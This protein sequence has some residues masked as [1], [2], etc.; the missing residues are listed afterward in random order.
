M[1]DPVIPS[2]GT[3]QVLTATT[4]NTAFTN[5]TTIVHNEATRA[6]AAENTNA[7]NISTTSSLLATE[8]ARAISAEG[9]LLSDVNAEATRAESVEQALNITL[10]QVTG[11]NGSNYVGDNQGAIGGSTLWTTVKGFIQYLLSSAGS[12]VVGFLQAGTGVVAR[13]VQAKL[14]ECVSLEDFG[15]VGD[16][17]TNDGPAAVL[18][19]NYCCATGATLRLKPRVYK[20]ARIEVH[21]TYCVEGNGATVMYLGVGQTIVLGTGTGSAA[22]PTAWGSDPGYQPSYPATTKYDLSVAPILGAISLT[23]SSVSGIT[24]GMYLF[25]CGNPTSLSSSNNFIP[26][27]FEF[28]RVVNIVGNVITLSA[29]LQSS[30]L[31]T[32]SGVFYAPGL[33]INCH[34][35]GLNISTTTDAYQQVVRSS[36]GCTIKDITFSGTSAVGASTFSD[37]LVYDNINVES[38]AGGGFSTGRGTV[39]TVFS[40]VNM[41]NY[42]SS[43]AFFF[44]ESAYKVTLDNFFAA[45]ALALGSFDCS[46]SQRHRQFTVQNSEF[47]PSIYGG[48]VSPFAAGTVIGIDLK[49]SNTTFYGAVTTPNAGNYPSITGDALIWQSASMASD[50]TLFNDCKFI[51]VNAGN[52]WPS[53]IGGFLG[54]VRFNSGC[55]FVT[56]TTPAQNESIATSLTVPKVNTTI[57]NANTGGSFFGQ[58][59][60]VS[61]LQMTATNLYFGAAFGGVPSAEVGTINSYTTSTTIAPF[62]AQ[63]INGFTGHMYASECI[64]AAGTGWMHFIGQSGNGTNLTTNN[65]FIYGNGNI[66]NANNSYGA[67]SDIKLKEN[68]TVCTPKL[69]KLN[70]VRV[71]NYNL[72]T[73]PTHKQIGV[74]AQEVEAIFPGM[75]EDTPDFNTVE[76]TREILDENGIITIEKYSENVYTGEFTKSVKYSVFI[77]MLIKAMQEQTAFISALEARIVSL[78]SA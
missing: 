73:D 38:A 35:S 16:G 68:I 64:T 28:F 59:G 44:E 18:A 77:P 53:A 49:I 67:I 42:T 15:A 63:A 55:T 17:V 19:C 31:T 70:Q 54:T 48:L 11:T 45:G 51:S 50:L 3:G 74:I 66:V 13:S 14:R 5:E 2:F 1:T 22:I 47:S 37:G 40:N 78:E 9:V 6:E 33:A 71:V 52:T 26:K 10:N 8:G 7:A 24:V 43:L 27:D 4:L 25:I 20:N 21:G 75:V 29:P 61:K 62:A 41:K 57:I 32:Q 23:L 36:I 34:I 39:S 56:C 65:V 72:K 76:K 60:G 12:S 30:Y 58:I 46:S 69:D